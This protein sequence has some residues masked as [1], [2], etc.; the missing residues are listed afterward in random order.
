[1][2]ELATKLSLLEVISRIS[3]QV[4]LIAPV[5]AFSSKASFG[6]GRSKLCKVPISSLTLIVGIELEAV[7]KMETFGEAPMVMRKTPLARHE[8]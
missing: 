5:K 4:F 7:L 6:K 3:T 2:L 1:M 8:S